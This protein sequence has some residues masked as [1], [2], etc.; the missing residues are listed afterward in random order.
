M[1]MTLM[2]GFTALLARYSGQDDIVLGVPIAN[3]NHLAS[4]DLIG[5]L[6][7]TL[8]LRTDLSG[9]PT[10]REHLRR[11]RDTLLDAYAHQDMPFDKLVLELQPRRYTSHSP[12]V[13]VLMNLL[14]V[15]MPRQRLTDLAWEPFQFDRGAAQFDLT[16]TVD[17]DREGWVCLEYS[18]D[19][20]DRPT[21][22]RIVD[23][24][25]VILRGAVA[26]PGPPPVG[27]PGC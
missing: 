7:N 25:E 22:A 5:D 15:P 13:R 9:D 3:R 19:L 20:F 27:D 21:A 8:P 23:H 4:E 14:N 16:L 18:S 6:V 2:A 1:F 11:V 12:L 10:F 24:F 17:W 26:D